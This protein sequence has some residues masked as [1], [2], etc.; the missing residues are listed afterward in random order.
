MINYFSLQDDK[1]FL[2]RVW[3]VV[4]PVSNPSSDAL[5]GSASV[6]LSVL[7]A[8]LPTISGWFNIIDD[9]DSINGQ[10]KVSI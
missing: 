10:I 6:D 1:R 2:I 3:R 4:Q 8:G 7:K 5:L 9:S